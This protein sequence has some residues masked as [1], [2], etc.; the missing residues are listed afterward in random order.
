VAAHSDGRAYIADTFNHAVRV[1]DPDGSVTTL[2]G[3][4]AGDAD[5]DLDDARLNFPVG[6]ALDETGARLFLV[7]SGNQKLRVVDLAAGTV[8]TLAGNGD[9]DG[10]DGVGAAASF[11]DPWEVVYAAGENALYVADS[12]GC[13]VRRVDGAS[14]A[15]TTVLGAFGDCRHQ[16]GDAASA[17]I[18]VPVGLALVDGALFVTDF[19]AHTLRRLDLSS[20][21][22]ATVLGQADFEGALIGGT[23]DALLSFPSGLAHHDGALFIAETGNHVVR[24]VD[25]DTFN[26]S[27]VLG[28]SGIPGGVPV[29]AVQDPAAVTTLLDPQALS[30]SAGAEGTLLWLVG[31]HAVWR[32]GPLP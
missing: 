15:V 4:A 32:S 31:D 12:S 10:R 18:V 23:D 25:V 20:G 14:A 9:D 8:S 3:G 7:D 28:V 2:L 13:T 21:A 5:G 24:R 1:V 19:A 30:T 16:D 17:R 6:L 26:S 29:G 27:F 11:S 22:V